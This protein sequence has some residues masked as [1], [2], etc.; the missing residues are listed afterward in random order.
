MIKLSHGSSKSLIQG[1]S[2]LMMMMMSS[3]VHDIQGVSSL[4]GE[5]KQRDGG[6][7]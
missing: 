1:V 5:E 7:K 4:E 3:D 2:M 6:V